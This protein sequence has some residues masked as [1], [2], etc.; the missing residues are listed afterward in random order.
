MSSSG[1]ASPE[2]S[3]PRPARRLEPLSTR[4]KSPLK[5]GDSEISNPSLNN[6]LKDSLASSSPTPPEA[7]LPG[8]VA[9][10]GPPLAGIHNDAGP[11]L[12]DHFPKASS[13]SAAGSDERSSAGGERSSV[14]EADIDQLIEEN[15]ST[16]DQDDAFL[17]GAGDRPFKSIRTR[18]ADE[19][20]DKDSVSQSS[21]SEFSKLG[22]RQPSR[23]SQAPSVWKL[24]PD[25]VKD[26]K[27]VERKVFFGMGDA[28]R[29][30]NQDRVKAFRCTKS[31]RIKTSAYT[32]LSFVPQNLFEQFQKSAN[33]YFLLLVILMIV[34]VIPESLPWYTMGAPLILVLIMAAL[35]DGLLD[36]KRHKADSLLNNRIAYRRSDVGDSWEEIKWHEV[37]IGDI[38]KVK[39]NMPVPAD[40][41]LILSSESKN[42]KCNIETADL[43]GETN[44]KQRWVLPQLMKLLP[45]MK[46]LDT[47]MSTHQGY[48]R[49]D[50]P[51]TNLER[52]NGAFY[53]GDETDLAQSFR[54]TLSVPGSAL[55]N[56]NTILRGSIVRHTE[57][58]V[59]IVVYVGNDTKMMMNT[60]NI[61]F[62]RTRMDMEMDT[63]VWAVGGLLLLCG[64]CG[65]IMCWCYMRYGNTL[66]FREAYNWQYREGD[67]RRIDSD[68]LLAGLHFFFVHYC[69]E[70][71]DSNLALHLRRLDSDRSITNDRL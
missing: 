10:A 27:E 25:D 3:G 32:L 33:K 35:K 34:P 26:G 2:G 55:E 57:F 53:I 23:G 47:F 70:H 42:G 56:E 43:D 71:N 61:R 50:A 21:V 64:A 60:G 69:D 1:T 13:P 58:A 44:L 52:F 30:K 9:S 18:F 62:K 67:S 63:I 65:S 12:L 28:S 8:F 20:R 19:Y 49:C 16:V 22:S 68:P 6:S 48:V 59:G 54:S 31:N 24:E 4:S 46:T 38:I 5:N 14:E 45:D 7:G 11:A 66:T 29:E 39:K 15:Q 41:V 40:M 51:N 36:M 37:R 17:D